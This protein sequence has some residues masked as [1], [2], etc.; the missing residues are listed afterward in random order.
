MFEK[1]K[2]WLFHTRSLTGNNMDKVILR[3]KRMTKT[4]K[5]RIKEPLYVSL[6][7]FF[8]IVLIEVDYE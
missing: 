4:G 6:L 3:A 1:F 8:K 2:I 5:W 7:G